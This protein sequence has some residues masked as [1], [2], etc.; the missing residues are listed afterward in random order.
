MTKGTLFLTDSN[1]KFKPVASD[2][3]FYDRWHYCVKFF[4]PEVT[5]I[6][7]S[8]DSDYI[9]DLLRKRS[10]WR[11][12]SRIR[13]PNLN[14]VNLASGVSDT[15]IENVLLLANFLK[16]FSG[17]YKIVI[18]VNYAW[19]YTSDQCLIKEVSELPYILP[20]KLTEAKITRQRDCVQLRNPQHQWRSYLRSCRLETVQKESLRQFLENQTDVRISAGLLDWLEIPWRRTQDYYFVDHNGAG[21]ETMMSLVVPQIIR[22]TL[23][24]M[25][26]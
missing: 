19:L 22:K 4:L 5:A 11:Q 9:R 3:L 26:K 15:D 7:D 8:L 14:T 20:V 17:S 10:E 23:P 24:I 13:W 6:R 16:K 25:A 18:S 12:Q 21:F 1:L 2:R